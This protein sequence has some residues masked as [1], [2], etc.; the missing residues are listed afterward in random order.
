MPIIARDFPELTATM[1]SWLKFAKS[2]EESGGLVDWL[3]RGGEAK[4]NEIDLGLWV[5][6]FYDTFG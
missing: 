3:E 1:G 4:V 2:F 5:V 6:G